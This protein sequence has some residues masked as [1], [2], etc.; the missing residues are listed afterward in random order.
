MI[1][2]WGCFKNDIRTPAVKQN[3]IS[4]LQGFDADVEQ[5]AG[6]GGLGWGG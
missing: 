1:S 6:G 5:A 4:L 3:F 2:S